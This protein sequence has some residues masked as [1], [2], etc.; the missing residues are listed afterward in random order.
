MTAQETTINTTVGG[1]RLI[2][3][4][5]TVVLDDPTANVSVTSDTAIDLIEIRIDD[6]IR[7]TYRPNATTFKRSVPLELD[8]NENTVEIIARADSVTSLK[9]TVNK[10]TASPR[11]KYS[12]PFSTSI[13]GGPEN[14]TSVS[15]GQ[16]T[17][18]GTLHTVSKVEQIRVERTHIHDGDDESNK[19]RKVHIITNPGESFSQSLLLGSGTNEIEA[20]YT[21]AAGRTNTDRFNITVSDAAT[22]TANLDIQTESYTDTARIRGTIQDETKIGRVAVERASNNGSQILLASSDTHPDPD[23]LSYEF[24]T[25]VDL[26]NDNEDNRFKL[27]AEDAAGNKKTQT[28]AIDYDPDPTVSITENRTNRTARTVRIAG[29]ISEANID[30]VTLE[31]I[32]T[33]SGE[34]LDLI[35]VYEAGTPTTAITFD[36]TLDAVPGETIGKLLIEY[37]RGQYTQTVTPIVRSQANT[38]SQAVENETSNPDLVSENKTNNE[39]VSD[40][41]NTSVSG[42]DSV[43]NSSTG[44]DMPAD[45]DAS[46]TPTL[47]PIRMRDALGGTVIVGAVY[48]FGHWV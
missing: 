13:K 47:I 17:L 38:T 46:A 41:E 34:R 15:G 22:P 5:E 35:R 28:F 18:A 44:E 23:R 30:R 40:E 24:E 42:T 29:N 14:E 1:D 7:H 8:P 6:E 31:T 45:G 26:Y 10:N 33:R 12:S 36:H 20:R 37:D 4:G 25:T 32:D 39:P 48:L 16:V 9:T 19:A 11:V 3:G 27:V 43:T 21:D 2:E